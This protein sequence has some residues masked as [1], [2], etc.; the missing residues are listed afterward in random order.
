[1]NGIPTDLLIYIIIAGVL[2]LWLR[3]TIGTRH[4]DERQRPNPFAK[5]SDS[6]DSSSGNVI[7]ITGQVVEL[8]DP[9][10]ENIDIENPE[11][12]QGLKSFMKADQ[13]FNPTEFVENAKDAFVMIVE[14]FADGDRDILQALLSESVYEGFDQALIAREKSGETVETEIHAIKKSEIIEVKLQDKMVF[15]SFQFTAEET[16]VIR[17]KDGKII[18]GDPDKTSELCDIWVFGRNL[19][20]KD[21]TWKLYETRDGDKEDH[22]TPL[23]DVSS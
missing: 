15:I 20:D 12:E 10:P 19:K 14:G 23:P 17:N 9:L 3:N 21:P 5:T 6:S 22:K 2:V 18:A 13:N 8:N 1:M 4:G 7:D 11:A 16:A